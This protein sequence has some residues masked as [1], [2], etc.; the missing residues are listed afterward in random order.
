[1]STT[2]SPLAYDDRGAGTPVVLLHGLT[3]D[4]AAWAPIVRK[5]GEGVRTVAIDLPG[6]GETGVLHARCGTQPRAST[7]R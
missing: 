5:L 3:F 4:R 7:R 1:M 6:H 2:T